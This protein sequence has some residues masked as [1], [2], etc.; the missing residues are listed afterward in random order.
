MVQL[1]QVF[2]KLPGIGKIIHLDTIVDER[3]KCEYCLFFA[4]YSF[5]IHFKRIVMDIRQLNI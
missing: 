4:S 2:L 3:K 1:Y 5:D